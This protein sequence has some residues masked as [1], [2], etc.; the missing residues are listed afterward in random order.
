MA[1]IYIVDDDAAFRKAT[2]RLLRAAGYDVEVYESAEQLLAR[3]PVQSE[4]GCILLDVIM[5]GLSGPEL[6]E[7]LSELGSTLPTVFLTA[8][9]EGPVQG[10]KY[11]LTKPV[12]KDTLLET[13][14]RAL[15]DDGLR[16]ERSE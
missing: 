14:E 1:I 13:I 12:S 16:D 2:S 9:D 5:P 7:R 3:L 8:A 6:Q 15:R 11:L 10:A 4:L